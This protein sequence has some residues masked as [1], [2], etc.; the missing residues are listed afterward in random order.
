MTKGDVDVPP[1]MTMKD[2][3]VLLRMTGLVRKRLQDRG[4]AS[5]FGWGLWTRRGGMDAGS[6]EPGSSVFAWMQKRERPPLEGACNSPIPA[7]TVPSRP[8]TA[9]LTSFDAPLGM[10]K[11]GGDAPLGMTKGAAML[12]SG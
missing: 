12:R 5:G 9:H 4:V 3:D 6:D 10:T 7:A 1:G 2:A 11:G 8:S